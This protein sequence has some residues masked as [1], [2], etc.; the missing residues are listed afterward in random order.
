M[1]VCCFFFL[2]AFFFICVLY[3][4]FVAYFSN[5]FVRKI[6]LIQPMVITLKEGGGRGGEGGG[7]KR[8]MVSFFKFKLSECKKQI[9][10]NI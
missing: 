9:Y 4:Y 5:V 3:A 2:L 8:V 1:V 7:V 10:A 6:R